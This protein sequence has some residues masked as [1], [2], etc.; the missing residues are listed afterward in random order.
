MQR[1]SECEFLLFFFKAY[2]PCLQY[3]LHNLFLFK[4][5]ANLTLKSVGGKPYCSSL[6]QSSFRIQ[7]LKIHEKSQKRDQLSHTMSDFCDSFNPYFQYLHPNI[8]VWFAPKILVATC[9][10]TLFTFTFC[11]HVVQNIGVLWVS[12]CRHMDTQ[13]LVVL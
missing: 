13:I 10:P 3:R 1:T 4:F 6:V 2:T 7:Q 12:I 5:W 9:K 11:F 8:G